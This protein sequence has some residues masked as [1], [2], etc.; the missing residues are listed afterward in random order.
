MLKTEGLM[1]KG[2]CIGHMRMGWNNIRELRNNSRGGWGRIP[3]IRG[4]VTIR[5][6][7]SRGAFRT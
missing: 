1:F 4:G 7:K 6:G 5:G 2:M 3:G